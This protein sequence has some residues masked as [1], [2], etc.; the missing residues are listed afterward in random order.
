MNWSIH[1]IRVRGIEIKIHLTFALILIWAA[2]TWGFGSGQGL[3]GA[4]FGVIATLLLFAGITLHEL[5]HSVQAM[6]EG[7]RVREIL[8]LPIGGVAQIDLPPGKPAAELRIAVAGPVVSLALAAFFYGALLLVGPAVGGVPAEIG[9]FPTTLTATALLG[10]L[11]VANLMLGLFNLLPAFPMDGG[12]I[13]R[14]LLALRLP[15]NRATAIAATLGQG[16]AWV[17]ALAGILTGNI[18]LILVGLFIWMGAGNE[19]AIVDA[20]STLRDLRV[21]D[22]MSRQPLVLSP[23]D[24]LAKAVELTLSNFQADFPV[25]APQ[26][27][28]TVG[29]LT[30]E[31]ILQGLRNRGLLGSV[32]GAMRPTYLTVH[33]ADPLHE[34]QLRL[35][36]SPGRCAVVVDEANRLVGLLTLADVSEALVMLA[37]TG[38]SAREAA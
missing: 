13:F 16:F 2:Y 9:L 19:A 5:G 11:A 18:V 38:T 1:L 27:E 14:A 8:L 23:A 6:R 21:A 12:R 15:Y 26:S 29:L 24:R 35:L 31:D 3:D 7:Y 28:R 17:F 10:Y 33:A 20:H 22:A 32:G 4:V 37:A 34:T 30:R 36:S 25:V